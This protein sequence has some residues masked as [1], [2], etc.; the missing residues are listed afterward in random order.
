MPRVINDDWADEPSWQSVMVWS[1]DGSGTGMYVDLDESAEERIAS[2]S[3]RWHDWAV[4]QLWEHR[5]TNWPE[6]PRHPQNH[7]LVVHL[8]DQRA[9]W[10]CPHDHQVVAR[11]GH[12]TTLSGG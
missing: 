6:C 9:S 12:L 8:A 5:S 4:E 7:P 2:V 11:V 1:D 10:V 3:D